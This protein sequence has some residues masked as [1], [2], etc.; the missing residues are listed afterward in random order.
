MQLDLTLRCAALCALMAAGPAGAQEGAPTASVDAGLLRHTLSDGYGT[1][2]QQFVRGVFGTSASDTWNA[3]VVHAREFGDSGTLFVV[4]NTHQFGERWYTSVAASG[5]SGGFF[6]PHARLDLTANRKM[7]AHKNLVGTLGVTAVDSK[8]GHRDRSV[9][10]GATY[11]FDSPWVLEGGIRMNRSN[12]GRVGSNGKYVAATWGRHHQ[13][14]VS[15]RYGFGSEAYQYVGPDA[16]LVDFNSRVW[17]ATWR[18]WLRPRQGI[19]LR[20]E[21]YRN[22]FYDRRGIELSAFQEF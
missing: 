2:T 20:A 7:L 1:W 9:L 3:E 14:I 17:T 15:L 18:T 10:L 4:G 16:L 21:A 12:P 22:P 6:F 8:D 19:Q 13:Q 5:S 11:Y